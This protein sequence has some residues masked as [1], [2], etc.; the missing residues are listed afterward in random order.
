MQSTESGWGVDHN[1]E[2]EREVARFMGSWR[3]LRWL[4]TLIHIAMGALAFIG[5]S[6]NYGPSFIGMVVVLVIILL[7]DVLPIKPA[8]TLLVA[9]RAGIRVLMIGV[10][11]FTL[12]RD[13][14]R[15]RRMSGFRY[16]MPTGEF[17]PTSTTVDAHLAATRQLEQAMQRGHLY[18]AAL[19]V[20]LA[21]V[22]Y[23]LTGGLLVSG[24]FILAMLK[25][26][27]F[28]WSRIYSTRQSTS[29]IDRFPTMRTTWEAGIRTAALVV[30]GTRPRDIDLNQVQDLLSAPRGTI[31]YVSGRLA[32]AA[33]LRDRGQVAYAAQLVDEALAASRRDFGQTHI[34]AQLAAAGFA[35]TVRNDPV[36]ARKLYRSARPRRGD[37]YIFKLVEAQILQKEERPEDA[38][39]AALAGLRLIPKAISKGDAAAAKEQLEALVGVASEPARPQAVAP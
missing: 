21:L 12:V 6:P 4:L 23:P 22:A 15:F 8:C 35:V 17:L 13:G 3:L 33:C 36:T 39:K 5:Y 27:L 38:R 18:T 28:R 20:V 19:F 14:A 10:A 34:S 11:P 24:L 16:P 32:A 25:E 26:L 30:E 9:R 37:Q 7:I 31:Q 1:L 29:F 2:S